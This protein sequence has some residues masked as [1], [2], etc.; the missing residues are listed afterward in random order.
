VINAEPEFVDLAIALGGEQPVYAVRSLPGVGDY[1]EDLV[2]A[3]ALRYVKDIQQAHPDGPL[4]L[5]GQCQGGKIAIA[6]AQHLLRRGRQPPLLILVEWTTE[7]ASYPGDVLLL[8]GRDSLLNPK[9][10]PFNLEPAWRRM[11]GSFSRAEVDGGYNELYLPPNI[12]SLAGE[13]ARR[14]RQALHRPRQFSPLTD[15]AYEFAVDKATWRVRRGAGLGFEISVKNTGSAAI[16]GEFSSLRLGGF[17]I[18]GG[19]IFRR[20]VEAWPL[21][22]IAPG[23]TSVVKFDLLAPENEGDFELALDLFEERGHALTGL[24]EASPCAR[25]K[26]T[27]RATPMRE[28]LRSFFR[29]GKH[30]IA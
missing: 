16:G 22:A 21:A 13:L 23:E 18:R 3:L 25:V 14:F 27:H 6:M 29:R 1:D 8:Y 2:Q 19:A 28:S 17:W 30:V 9:F 11:F 4:F 10:A 12:G 24:G 20:F 7:P 15:C 26:V 5:L